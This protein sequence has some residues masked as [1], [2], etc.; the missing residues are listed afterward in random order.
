VW[1]TELN[2]PG[3][4]RIT[5]PAAVPTSKDQCKHGGWRNLTDDQARPFRNQGQCVDW[6][7]HHRR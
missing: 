5:V 6:A 2:G 1:F 7:V 3:I 4:G